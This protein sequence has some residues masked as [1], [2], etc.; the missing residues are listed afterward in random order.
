[1]FLSFD[2]LHRFNCFTDGDIFGL[3]TGK[4]YKKKKNP[5]INYVSATVKKVV[6]SINTTKLNS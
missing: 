4:K 1:M 3:L 6:R 5:R 2:Y